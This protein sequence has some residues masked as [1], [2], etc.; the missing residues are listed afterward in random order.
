MVTARTIAGTERMRNTLLASVSHDFR[1][2]LSSILGA[3]TSLI[4]YGDRLESAS[5]RDLL[6]Q[7]KSEAEGLD[8]M[9]KN[10]LAIARIDSGALELRHD[11]VDLRETVERVV[12]ASRRRGATQQ[13]EMRFAGDAPLVWA[14]ATLIEQA[15]TNV[16]GNTVAHTPKYTRVWIDFV[17]APVAISLRVTDDGLGIDPAMLPRVFEKFFR[18]D[19]RVG[20]T[21]DGGEGTGLGLAIAKGIMDAHGGSI[22]V[23]SPVAN[24]RGARFVLS[25]P[26]KGRPG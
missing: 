13:F 14:D 2:P 20:S 23:Q 24:G 25:F 6:T 3:A 1:T 26:K 9:V 17:E 19:G 18:G 7:I 11:W 15:V 5:R 16:I 22:A 8:E 21:A 12:N 4:D 10:L